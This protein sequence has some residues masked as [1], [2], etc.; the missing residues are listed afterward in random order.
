MNIYLDDITSLMITRAVSANKGITLTPTGIC[1][2]AGLDLRYVKL[3][4]LGISGLLTYL[5]IPESRSLGLVV[6]KRKDRIRAHGIHCSVDSMQRDGAPFSLLS[7]AD[8]E[9]PSPLVSSITNVYV[10]HP[11][12]IVLGMARR[13]RRKELNGELSGQQ[14]ILLLV[15]LCLELCGTYSHDP[16]D[17]NHA[18]VVFNT[19]QWLTCEDLRNYLQPDGNEQGLSLARLAASM[20]YDKSG[21]PQESFMGPALF[22]SS[23]LGGLDLGEFS[24][25]EPLDLSEQERISINFRT[26]TPDFQL[27]EYNSVVEYLGEIHKEGDNPRI[28]H[29]R[30]LDYQTL[31]KREFSF[32]YSDVDTQAHFMESAKRI[33]SAIAQVEGLDIWKSFGKRVGRPG[34]KE[35]QKV[36]FSVFRPWLRGRQ[37]VRARGS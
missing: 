3:D 5:K 13:I 11:A 22:Y 8:S 15:K 34:F 35:R 33:V 26:I 28:D 1:R 10:Q 9:R 37:G 27:P 2:P 21:S 17:P 30:S 18:D 31:G 25:N 14:A 24:A 12:K 6:P 7:S 4:R 32:W 23:R 20:S 19:K 29:T 36:L 16:F